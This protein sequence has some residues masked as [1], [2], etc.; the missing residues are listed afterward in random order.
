MDER[1]EKAYALMENCRLCPRECGVNRLKGELGYCKMGAQ[2][3]VS[4]AGPHFGEE[5][6]L[7]GMGGSGTIFLTGCN[8]G[9]LFC[10]NYDISHYRRGTETTVDGVADM[11]LQLQR[12]GCHNINLVTPTH[13]MPPLIDA[14]LRARE[15]GLQLPLVWNCGGY[16]SIE[17]LKLL[18]GI[19]D[20]Y[21]PDAKFA[22]PKSAE[23]YCN[24][25]D[26]WEINKAA[27]KEMHR[28]VGDL[29]IENGIAKRGLLI[30][31]LVM[32]N[33]V[34]KSIEIIDFIAD[35]ISR[36]TYVNVMEQYRPLY[37]AREFPEIATYPTPEEFARV[38]FH[39]KKRGLRLD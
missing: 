30:R 8:L 25:P 6:P 17:A 5:R 19:V 31:H 39:A 12:I 15:R 21:M 24:A 38:Y 34:A 27:L 16:E 2:P 4:S 18:E 11:M 1:V 10:Q 20:I 9:C 26:Y 14:F 13:F 28:Q 7:V 36:N 29:K 3:V 33:D 32:P 23:K 37:R 35:E 22:D